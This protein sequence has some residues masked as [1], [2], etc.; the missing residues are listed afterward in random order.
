MKCLITGHTSGIG[1]AIYN[2]FN[3]IG[4]NVLG[5]SKSNGFNFKEKYQEILEIAVDYDV[6]VNN[7]YYQD[8]QIKFLNDLSNKV[9]FIISLGSAAGYYHEK[10]LTKKEYCLNKNQLSNLTKKLSFNS[11]TNFLTLNVAMTENV[12]PDFGCS[13]KDI[14][15]VCEFWLKNPTFHSIDFNLKLTD[16]N[17]KLVKNEFGLN[18]EDIIQEEKK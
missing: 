13:Y 3:E 18:K 14:T 17:M 12:T 4:F 11:I 6:F 8:Y 15:N 7:A 16:L 9:P 10:A 5:I 1:L 2:R